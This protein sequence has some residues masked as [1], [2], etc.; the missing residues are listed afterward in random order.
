[1]A[2]ARSNIVTQK[3]IQLQEWLMKQKHPR[4]ED[5]E[6]NEAQSVPI[7]VGARPV[8]VAEERGVGWTD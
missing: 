2:E 1:M 5:E 6:S 4:I 7:A 3:I 8:R